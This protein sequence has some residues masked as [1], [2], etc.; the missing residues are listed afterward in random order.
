MYVPL[1]CLLHS[2]FKPGESFGKLAKFEVAI[3][4]LVQACAQA[5]VV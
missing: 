1:F 5:F 4:D 2:S 3:S